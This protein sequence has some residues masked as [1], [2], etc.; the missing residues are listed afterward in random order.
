MVPLY[1]MKMPTMSNWD[2]GNL[3]YASERQS[4]EPNAGPRALFIAF[5]GLNVKLRTTP[6][7]TT[8]GVD[9]F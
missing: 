4:H 3:I 2:G 6:V 7:A 8:C 5:M 1:A 9:H